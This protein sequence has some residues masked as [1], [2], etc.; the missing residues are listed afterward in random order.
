MRYYVR[1][2]LIA[3]DE[4]VIASHDEACVADDHTVPTPKDIKETSAIS[5]SWLLKTSEVRS[6]LGLTG[7]VA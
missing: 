4:T 2:L 6:L 1:T 3:F 7:E 5:T